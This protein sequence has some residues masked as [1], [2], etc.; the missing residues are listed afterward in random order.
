[1]PKGFKYKGTHWTQKPENKER[2]IAM[3]SGKRKRSKKK[4]HVVTQQILSKAEKVVAR[5]V[6]KHRIK[7][8]STTTIQL[9]GWMVTLSHGNIKIEESK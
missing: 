9:N 2:L 8:P 3:L 5:E 1:M 4:Q 6:R 7:V